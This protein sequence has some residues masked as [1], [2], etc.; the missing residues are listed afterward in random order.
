VCPTC[1]D[2]R[3]TANQIWAGWRLRTPLGR[4]ENVA[5]VEQPRGE[6]GPV[7]IWTEETGD[8]VPFRYWRLAKVDARPPELTFHGQPELRVHEMSWRDGPIYVIPTMNTFAAPLGGGEHVLVE[9]RHVKGEGWQ[10][11]HRPDPM[12]DDV[13][14]IRF[15]NKAKA[16]A[17]VRR[18][19]R[20]YAKKMGLKLAVPKAEDQRSA[21]D[22]LEPKPFRPG[23]LD[24][25]P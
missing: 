18:L 11:V 17:E 13:V 23:R 9:A 25:G 7:L 1:G 3:A 15:A 12:T 4:W 6:Y 24:T 16:R 19:G 22:D 21:A 14:V 2:T 5:R 10:V 8:Q 20:E